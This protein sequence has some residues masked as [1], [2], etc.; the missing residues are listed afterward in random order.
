M[1]PSSLIRP[2][3]LFPTC[4]S[5]LTIIFT[6]RIIFIIIIIITIIS[7]GSNS[8]Y[9]PIYSVSI[10]LFPTLSCSCSSKVVSLLAL[11][12]LRLSYPTSITLYFSNA[13]PASLTPTTPS[14]LPSNAS[15]AYTKSLFPA[16]SSPRTKRM[17]PSPSFTSSVASPASSPSVLDISSWSTL[18]RWGQTLDVTGRRTDSNDGVRSYQRLLFKWPLA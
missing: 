10:S 14:Y 15:P 7:L 6:I 5:A 4:S 9:V 17:S 11:T 13:P 1:F 12:L 3:A 18:R 2:L 8:R 16:P